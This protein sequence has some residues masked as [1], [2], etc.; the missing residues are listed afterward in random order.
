M[1]AVRM[2]ISVDGTQFQY[3]VSPN[4]W[5]RLGRKPSAI[6]VE[7]SDLRHWTMEL[8]NE[9]F[10]ANWHLGLAALSKLA[11][12]KRRPHETTVVTVSRAESMLSEE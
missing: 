11:L 1:L 2:L 4:T 12:S 6:P 9:I 10:D 8:P 3:L 7:F 5:I